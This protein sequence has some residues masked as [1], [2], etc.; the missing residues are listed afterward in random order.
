M[1]C[2]FYN[3]ID[4]YCVEWL[5]N[6][7]KAG[8]IA[9]GVVDDRSI[10]E[11]SPDDLKGF[12]QC[13][14]FAG[15]GGWSHALR[16]AGWPDDRP[17]WTGSCPCQPFSIAG[18]KRG[19]ED[20]RHLWPAWF[21]LIKEQKPGTIF[22]EQVAGPNGYAWWDHVAADMEGEGYAAAAADMHAAGAC[23]RRPRLY[24]VADAGGENVSGHKH[25]REGIRRVA[26]EASAIDG[27]RGIH[28]WIQN[29]PTSVPHWE[30]DGLSR[31]VGIMRA[32]GNAI[33]PQQAEA[34]IRAYCDR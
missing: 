23:H 18:A 13:H 15:L 4:P 11:V 26:G 10:L 25:E 14:F 19:S 31:P 5:R 27:N 1:R 12:T 8:H 16:L 21:R 7:I 6:L 33:V 9:D 3:E 30:D 2:A 29:D 24:F 20:E 22:G 28:S 34:F 17:V 32:Y